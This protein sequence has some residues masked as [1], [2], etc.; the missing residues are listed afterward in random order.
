[1]K[2]TN[3]Y[4][5]GNGEERILID[6]GEGKENYLHNLRDVLH[7]ENCFIIVKKKISQI[8]IGNFINYIYYYYYLFYSLLLS[9]LLFLLF[10]Y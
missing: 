1:M 2:G 6:T 3:T 8:L 9:L 5:V 10:F 7:S 4:L